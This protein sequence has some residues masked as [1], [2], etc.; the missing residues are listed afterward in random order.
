MSIGII[1]TW[2]SILSLNWLQLLSACLPPGRF[3]VQKLTLTL[4]LKFTLNSLL[5]F[6]KNEDART[7]TLNL[8]S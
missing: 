4:T 1:M 6:I 8:F 2:S 5:H 7:S 3:G